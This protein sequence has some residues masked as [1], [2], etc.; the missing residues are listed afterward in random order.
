MWIG[1]VSRDE[2]G[3]CGQGIDFLKITTDNFTSYYEALI[4]WV[5]RLRKEIFPMDKPWEKEDQG[6]Y[7]RFREILS[8][9]L[10]SSLTHAICV[11]ACITTRSD[12]LF[13]SLIDHPE[14]SERKG[15][16]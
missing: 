7:Q 10:F 11:L 1:R 8:K 5:N 15:K 2:I 13:S 4:P 16:S 3:N 9:S 14:I 6:L 12:L